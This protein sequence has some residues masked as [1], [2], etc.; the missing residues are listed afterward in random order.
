MACKHM[1][2]YIVEEPNKLTYKEI[3]A[4]YSKPILMP[5]DCAAEA[6]NSHSSKTGLGKAGLMSLDGQTLYKCLVEPLSGDHQIH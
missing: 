5:S 4:S 2:K 6:I 3:K 1:T